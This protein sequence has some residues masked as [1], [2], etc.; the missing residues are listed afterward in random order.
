MKALVLA[1]ILV[2]ATVALGCGGGGGSSPRVDLAAT[3]YEIVPNVPIGS[4]ERDILTYLDERNIS[5][6]SPETLGGYPQRRLVASLNK[7]P[8]DT[9]V[10]RAQLQGAVGSNGPRWDVFF[11][12]DD[13]RR[14]KEIVPIDILASHL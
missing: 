8:D 5:H 4:S 14:L 12:L 3:Y 13:A 10:I 7:Y 9:P 1:S 6:D 11:I 2:T